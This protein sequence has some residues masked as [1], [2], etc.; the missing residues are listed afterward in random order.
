MGEPV[1]VREMEPAYRIALEE[2]GRRNDAEADVEDWVHPPDHPLT[3]SSGAAFVAIDGEVVTGFIDGHFDHDHWD[4]PNDHD[5]RPSQAWVYYIRVDDAH[6]RR[7]IG[8]ALLLHFAERARNEG[9]E[10]VS[11]RVKNNYELS[12]DPERI[13]RETFYRCGMVP[14]LDPEAPSGVVDPSPEYRGSIAGIIAAIA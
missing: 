9:C 6:Q 3:V 14:V 5:R 2:F 7:H 11:L 10:T 13:D 12:S 4:E 8:S 1:I